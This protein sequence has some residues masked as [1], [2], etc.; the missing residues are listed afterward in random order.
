MDLGSGERSLRSVKGIHLSNLAWHSIELTHDHHNITMT[1]DRNSRASLRMPGPDLELSV[2]Q[3]LYVGMAA[4]LNHSHLHNISAG[5]RGCIDEVVFNEHNLLASLRP[6][7][8]YKSVHEVSL[9]CSPQFSA[10]EEDSVS[11]FSSKAF[12]SLPPWEMP[13]EGVFECEVYPSA[14]Q[15]DG[16]ILYSSGNQGEFVALEIRD[17]HLVATVQNEE[18]NK[19]VLRSLTYVHGNQTW[20]PIQLHLLPHSVQL[21]VGEELV[22]ANVELKV[23]QLNGPLFLGGMDK[24]AYGEARRAGLMPVVPG[25][26]PAGGGGGSFKGCLQAIRVNTQRVGLPHATIT[27]DITVGC[28]TGQAPDAVI[29]TSPTDLPEFVVMT[30]QPTTNNKRNFLLLRKLEVMEGGRAPL[31][32]KHMRVGMVVSCFCSCSF[33][34][35]LH[36]LYTRFT[37]ILVKTS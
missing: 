13:Q 31:E 25:G 2:E 34:V 30:T 11:F 1:V 32:P 16:M 26:K 36:I 9:G 15:E 20:Y 35:F 33:H 14:R 19:T 24:E 3:G 21:K 8:G 12:I 10:T 6:Y 7:S 18:G 27:K 5:F 28:K 37:E 4:G 23:I 22:R 29:T 17:G